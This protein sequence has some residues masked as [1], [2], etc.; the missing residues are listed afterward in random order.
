VGASPSSRIFLQGAP[1]RLVVWEPQGQLEAEIARFVVWYGTA[2]DTTEGL[3][4]PR[5]TMYTTADGNAS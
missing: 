1:L 5:P 3:A 2:R 4:P